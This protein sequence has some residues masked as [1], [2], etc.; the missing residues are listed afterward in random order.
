MAYPRAFVSFDFDHDKTSRNLFIGQAKKD[1]PTPFTV[2]DW[3]SKLALPE[4]QWE[5]F[6]K[7]K[8]N[9]CLS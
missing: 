6:I 5:P 4:R 3:S 9:Q 2:A 8:I 1:S 7:S